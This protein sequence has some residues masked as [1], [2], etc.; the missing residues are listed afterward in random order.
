MHLNGK[1]VN[2]IGYFVKLIN[3]D[4]LTLKNNKTNLDILFDKKSVTNVITK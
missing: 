2:N 4:G 3:V 1:A